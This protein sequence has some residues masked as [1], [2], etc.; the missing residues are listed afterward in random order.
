MLVGT[1]QY[2]RY[3]FRRWNGIWI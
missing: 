1:H 3:T 2:Y